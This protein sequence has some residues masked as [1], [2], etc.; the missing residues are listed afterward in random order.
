MAGQTG[1][2]GLG[3]VERVYEDHLQCHSVKSGR[4]CG[5]SMG[6]LDLQDK[7][8]ENRESAAKI[9]KEDNREPQNNTRRSSATGGRLG[10]GEDGDW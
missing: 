3:A 2:G 7:P 5:T 1:R 4:V 6:T 10:G 9:S 8:D